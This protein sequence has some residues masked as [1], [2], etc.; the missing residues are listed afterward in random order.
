MGRATCDASQVRQMDNVL[1]NPEQ[2]VY[3]AKDRLFSTGGPHNPYHEV[4]A[5]IYFTISIMCSKHIIEIISFF[6]LQN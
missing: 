5:Q 4:A 3:H 2:R 6:V 1:Q